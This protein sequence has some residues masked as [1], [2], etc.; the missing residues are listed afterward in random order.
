M[1]HLDINNPNPGIETSEGEIPDDI[2][3][4]EDA[5]VNP[6]DV[7]YEGDGKVLKPGASFYNGIF[8]ESLEDQAQIWYIKDGASANPQA[9]ELNPA[10]KLQGEW[11]NLFMT[12]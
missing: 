8:E 6:F 12:K 10:Q 11:K 1:A 9:L 7:G 3:N 2:G 5:N 4:R